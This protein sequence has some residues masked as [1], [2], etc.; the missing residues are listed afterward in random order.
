VRKKRVEGPK[1]NFLER[2]K[3]RSRP[4]ILHPA[5]FVGIFLS[6]GL[7]F[8]LQ[9]WIS[10]RNWR[11]KISASLLVEAWVVQYFLWGAI[12]WLTWLWLG[13]RIQQGRLSW[14]LTCV[15][16]LSIFVGVGE[17]MFWVLMFPTLPLGS[18]GWSYRRRLEFHLNAELMDNLVIFW[19]SF[20]LIRGVGYYQ[21][22]REKEQSSQQLEVQ[23]VNAQLRALQMQLNPHFLFNTLNGISSLMHTD[24]AA[25]DTML[26][27]LSCLL[28]ITLERGEAQLIPLS[29]EMQFVEMYLELQNRRFSGR[30]HQKVSVEPELYDS[31]VP[32]MILQPIIENAFT[33]GLSRVDKDGLLVIEAHRMHNRI[34]LTVLNTGVGLSRVSSK[35]TACNGVG[36]ANVKNRLELH[37]GNDQR[38]LMRE[39][40]PNRVL[41][42]ITFPLQ[43]AVNST[44]KL[45]GLGAR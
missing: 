7:L 38:F 23:L 13:P 9:D 20:L 30:L 28:R 37:Y 6:I 15:L 24:I 41:V 5:V 33:H 12:C 1:L 32:A 10:A 21:K 40:T 29:D 43:F 11:Y 35:G 19:S 4:L 26:E 36:L 18:S 16:P 2:L 17:E 44:S 42:T 34:M 3:S 45:A 31:L 8:A 39:V 14:I 22:Y 27:Q 25:A